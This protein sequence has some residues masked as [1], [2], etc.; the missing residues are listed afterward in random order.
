MTLRDLADKAKQPT[1]I[2]T[3]QTAI[4]ATFPAVALAVAVASIYLVLYVN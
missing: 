2:A 4:M 3:W 1:G